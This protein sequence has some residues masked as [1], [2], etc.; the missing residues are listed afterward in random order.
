MAGLVSVRDAA[1]ASAWR[2]STYTIKR[3]FFSILGRKFH[4]FAPDGTPVAFVRHPLMRLREEFTIYTDDS[5]TVALLTMKAR[6]F[7]AFNTSH[8]VVDAST[9]EHFGNVRK[10]GLK[11]ILRDT[12]EILDLQEQP[13]GMMQEDGAALLR[14]F[15]PILPSRHH[16][17]LRG[18]TVARVRQIFRFFVKEF[19]LTVA[20][21][22]ATRIDP[23]FAVACAL[24][25][26]MAEIQ[27][28]SR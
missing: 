2:H 28:E 3:P 27:R 10:R 12:W 25:A 8:D 23:R 7:I 20:S 24:L 13:I 5:E 18:A 11:S 17:E 14:R 15:L 26:L 19:E 1:L 16:I 6:E 21:D 4:V 9:G 22:G